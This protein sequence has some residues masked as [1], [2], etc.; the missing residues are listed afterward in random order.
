MQRTIA[1]AVTAPLQ[2]AGMARWRSALGRIA[3]SQMVRNMGAGT[4]SAFAG[5]AL[6]VISYPIYLRYLGL[7]TYGLWL[8]LTV[9]VTL[10]QLGSLGIPWALTR[11]VAED[12]GRGDWP[13]VRVYIRTASVA[14]CL[15]G[16][17]LLTAV[18]L[19]RGHIVTCFGL[20]PAEAAVV[21]SL[22]PMAAALSAF[23]LLFSTVNAALGGLGRMDLTSFHEALAQALALAVALPLLRS[24]LGIRTL[25][26]ANFSAYAIAHACVWRRLRGLIPRT[27]RA[28]WGIDAVRLRNLL[29]T[30]GW[31][32]GAG[33]LSSLLLPVDRLMLSRYAGLR[34]VTM[35][36]LCFT[37]S[38]RIRGLLEAGFRPIMPEMGRVRSS[39]AAI[40][41]AQRSRRIDRGALKVILLAA[42]PL[43]GGLML[44]AAPA[45]RLWLHRS[46]DPA[47]PANFRIMLLGSMLSLIGFPGYYLLISLGR[48]RDCFAAA[49][50]QFTVNLGA[51]LLA[52]TRGRT[53][54]LTAVSCALAC[55]AGCCT[56]FIRARCG[57]VI[58]GR[59][60]HLAAGS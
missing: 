3:E 41:V 16:L 22:L 57:R 46:F 20:A 34:A 33:V 4:C 31:I 18:G 27:S 7:R 43:Y 12:R 14:I 40:A 13:G 39:A 48:A 36:D 47:L 10:A 5:A 24:G 59:R 53:L 25:L 8:V 9:V 49:S 15:V 26:I 2:A 28:P 54:S 21:Y 44:L 37:G 45:L 11:L 35:N 19:L 29:G 50:I 30:G 55:A 51:I 60:A 38:M 17:T 52:M 42:T 23:V 1:A 32:L 6:S 58:G 56:L